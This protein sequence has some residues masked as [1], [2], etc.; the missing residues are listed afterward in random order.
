MYSVCTL[1]FLQGHE[2]K[3]SVPANASKYKCNPPFR[4]LCTSYLPGTYFATHTT[5]WDWNPI[6]QTGST[7]NR[8][9]KTQPRLPPLIFFLS[10]RL[11][12]REVGKCC[13]IYFCILRQRNEGFWIIPCDRVISFSMESE[14]FGFI[15][16]LETVYLKRHKQ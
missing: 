12:P 7:R 15:N 16:S 9:Q 11:A 1:R 6:G 3:S 5:A 2:Y 4:S 13:Y 10:R 8:P 14:G